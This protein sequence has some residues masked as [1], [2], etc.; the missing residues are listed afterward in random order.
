MPLAP[1]VEAFC[2]AERVARL[3]TVDERGRPHVVPICFVLVQG[4]TLYSVLDQ[5]PKSVPP[6]RL[7]R[8]RNLLARP[9]VQVVVDRYD[10]D[11]SRLAYVQLRGRARLLTGGP[12]H[13]DAVRRLRDKY[14][15]YWSMDIEERPVIAI[16]LTD[17]VAWGLPA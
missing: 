8:V 13:E 15:Q 12:E 2:S 16:D 10:E 1:T 4:T 14:G 9:D 6:E 7:R 5:K 17:V 11:W 3:A